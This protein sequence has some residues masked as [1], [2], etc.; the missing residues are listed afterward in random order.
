M[1]NT[2]IREKTGTDYKITE[3]NICGVETDIYCLF[4]ISPS[5]DIS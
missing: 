4:E 1:E 2:E 3:T 5:R